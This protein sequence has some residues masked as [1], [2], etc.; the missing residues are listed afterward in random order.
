MGELTFLL[1]NID[2]AKAVQ[3]FYAADE[4]ATRSKQKEKAAAATAKT[5]AEAKQ[6]AD[7]A[8]PT[9]PAQR[10]QSP[11]RPR[12]RTEKSVL[13]RALERL[14]DLESQQ[15]GADA[16]PLAL[17]DLHRA[18]RVVNRVTTSSMRRSTLRFYQMIMEAQQGAF[19]P[20]GNAA[21]LG[22]LAVTPI[23]PN[24]GT[25]SP[26]SLFCSEL[27]QQE[28]ITVRYCRRV[29]RAGDRC[30]KHDIQEGIAIRLLMLLGGGYPAKA[31]K[32]SPDLRQ[33]IMERDNHTCQLCGAPAAEIDHIA[34]SSDDPSNLRALCK[35]CNLELA[36]SKATT[37]T[38]SSNPELFM[39]IETYLM[40][41]AVRI[42]A[43]RPLKAC[44]DDGHWQAIQYHLRA[45]RQFLAANR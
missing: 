7:S 11:R 5:S 2:P 16:P 35:P 19:M 10:P 21:S 43:P 38:M 22:E 6:S 12:S 27:C 29:A 42:A 41:L 14:K 8:E 23:C 30:L 17:D 13:E 40:G 24:C 33:Y 34:S 44:D 3:E 1:V 31:R 28:A 15:Q 4:E 39:K 9:S 20:V 32:L 45:A 26:S 36:W 18:A 25:E 37:V